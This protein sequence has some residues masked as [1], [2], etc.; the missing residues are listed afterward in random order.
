MQPAGGFCAILGDGAGDPCHAHLRPPALGFSVEHSGTLNQ[1]RASKADKDKVEI[2][3]IPTLNKLVGIWALNFT[4]DALW[5]MWEFY[6]FFCTSLICYLS[7]VKKGVAQI[8]HIKV[9]S[10]HL[11]TF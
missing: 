5:R 3:D 6:F 8:L 7:P 4:Q 10:T 1:D 9:N 11:S 2:N